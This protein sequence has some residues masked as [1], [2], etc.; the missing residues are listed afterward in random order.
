MISPGTC[1]NAGIAWLLVLTLLAGSI[2]PL[3]LHWTPWFKAWSYTKDYEHL[4]FTKDGRTA[5]AT[6]GADISVDNQYVTASNCEAIALNLREMAM[7]DVPIL[8]IVAGEGGS[9]GALGIAVGDRVLMQEFGVYSVIPPEGCAAI[10]WRDLKR[11]VDA[12]E[13]LR[14]TAPDLLAFGVIDEIVKEPAGG[15][16]RDHAAMAKNLHEALSRNLKEL[17]EVMPDQLIELRYQKFRK[18]SR[19]ME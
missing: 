1:R 11:K 2:V 6:R 18:M 13:A 7:L 3:Y 19:F 10:L 4:H 12:A 17:K 14:I 8:V 16:H 9:G 15:A 5:I